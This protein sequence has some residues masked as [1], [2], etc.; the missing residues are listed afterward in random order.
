MMPVPC[1][2]TAAVPPPACQRALATH[3]AGPHLDALTMVQA[4]HLRAPCR[5]ALGG[6]RGGDQ[7]PRPLVIA[8]LFLGLKG[9]SPPCIGGPRRQTRHCTVLHCDQRCPV[10]G[11]HNHG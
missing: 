6:G 4:L 11:S 7:L 1:S 5:P 10:Q 9:A 3:S 2:P 8:S